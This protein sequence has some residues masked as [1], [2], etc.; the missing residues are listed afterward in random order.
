MTEA[1]GD[2][3]REKN[4]NLETEIIKMRKVLDDFF[5]NTDYTKYL[6]SREKNE[7]LEIEIIKM[8]KVLD[9]FFSNTDYTKYLE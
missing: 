2:E 7:N 6:E 9:D 4:E 8:R 1:E 5:S 3:L